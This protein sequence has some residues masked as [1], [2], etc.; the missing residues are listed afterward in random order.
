MTDGGVDTTGNGHIT[1]LTSFEAPN[2][3]TIEKRRLELW[4]MA[5]FLLITTVA[6]L[7]LV[8]FW[9]K[10]V[11][12]VSASRILVSSSIVLLVVL[13]S[14]HAITK[15]LHLRA[16]TEELM[17]E[18][19]LAA[20]LT[21]S[22]REASAL[23]ESGKELN[24]RLDLDQVLETILTC[25]LELLDAQGSS[26]M[27]MCSEDELRTVCSRGRSSAG[28]ARVNLRHGIAGRVAATHEPVLVNG[29]F[30]WSHYRDDH[31]ENRPTSALSIPLTSD[32]NLVG[33]LNINAK[34]DREYSQRDL[35]AM[36]RFGKQAGS[37]IAHVQAFEA[38]R[39]FSHRNE[40]QGLHDLLTGLPNRSLLLDRVGNALV[41]R[42]P[43]GHAVVLLF[44]DLD[45]FKRVNDSLGHAAGDQVLIAFAERLQNSVRAGDSVAH[46]GGDE[47]AILLEAS[48]SE[49]AT[50]AA[51]RIL[52]DLSK[53]FPLEGGREVRFTASIGIALESSNDG[54]PEELMRN[55][56]TAL[57]VA[58][59]RGK[60]QVAIF[61]Q[62]MHSSALNR[63]DLEHELRHAVE[64]D[65]LDVHFQ[66]LMNLE[67]LSVYGFEAL[68]R[69]NHPRRGL[70]A[71]GSFVP[72]AEE[73]GLQ[74][75]IDRMVLR[76]TCTRI[77]ELNSGIFASSP[78]AAH[79]NLSPNTI[80]ETD[81]VAN[82]AQ[83]LRE[84]NLDPQQLVLEITEGVMMHNV[85]QAASKL[86]AV[87]S[88]GVRLALDDFGT[89]YSS[90][91]YLRSF[92][93]DVVKI[94]KIFVDEIEHD[95]GAEALVQAILRLGL[96]LTF[97]VV[98][99]G[100]ETK[101]QLASLIDLGCRYGQG[102]LLAK[103]L[104]GPQLTEFVKRFD[105]PLKLL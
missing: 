85:E 23:I 105:N 26:I 44:L 33:V 61:E 16:L 77:K 58:K 91:S 63:L 25:S 28:G 9:G 101:E 71:A 37:A 30:D 48:D 3:E 12:P 70:V 74:P 14:A 92:P 43:P 54:R 78:A 65:E 87:K 72:L 100:I 59:E 94:D 64:H 45:D 31:K 104:S 39:K 76:Q 5:L 52:G 81:F 83:D 50:L 47:F 42:R 4:A 21:N 96:G 29:K 20:A 34:P 102:Y 36:S 6:I 79:V 89:G 93:V 55:A 62:A 60:G 88:L 15:E 11:L 49:E 75:Q 95:R 98:A 19:V 53:P 51:E 86:R 7:S 10:I 18:R 22:L 73:A 46:F 56:F 40:Y 38:Q 82:L 80:R 69:W 13:F 57:H 24:L 17:D 32:G 84:S 8:V 67:E 103:P 1:G 90:L 27:M 68:V 2:L 66:P 99:E 35:R 97:E 41:R